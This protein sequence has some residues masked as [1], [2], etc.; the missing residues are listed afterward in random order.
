MIVGFAAQMIDGSL[1]MGY[2]V[3]SNSF[4]LMLG[5]PP[6]LTSSSVHLSKMFTNGAAGLS[7]IRFGNVDK[8]LLIR[9]I[10]T[11]VLG[12]II[13]ALVLSAL[14]HGVARPFVAVYLFIAGLLI[15]RKAI[16]RRQA[17]ELADATINTE[18]KLFPLGAL[19][20]FLDA[21]GGGGWGPVVTSTLIIRGNNPRLSIGSGSVAEF[22]VSVAIFATFS[23]RFSLAEQG[24][25]ILGLII[26][27]VLA[28]PL[29]AY[30]CGRLPV[31]PSLVAVGLLIMGVSIGML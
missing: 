4:L 18:K 5:I 6:A 24:T 20:G 17:V 30:L 16:R 11:G 25:V 12:G 22:F 10:P 29:S 7:H 14:P 26:G 8:R 27:G 2:G 9:L 3:I 1:G 13:G 28:A 31:R 15:I 23:S 21:I 19:G